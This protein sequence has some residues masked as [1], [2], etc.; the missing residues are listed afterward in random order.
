MTDTVDRADQ[1]L[2][3]GSVDLPTSDQIDPVHSTTEDP[4]RQIFVRS[5][6]T[7]FVQNPFVV[8]K[9]DGV[10]YWDVN[11]KKILDGLSGIYVANLGHNNRRVIDAVKRQMD[12]MNFS[13]PMHGTNPLSIRLANKLA[14]VAPGDLDAVKLA[15]GGSESTETAIAIA[16][17]YHK[18]R[19]NAT[20]FKI[21]SRYQ[22]WHGATLGALSASGLAS[23]RSYTEPLAAGF[24]HALRLPGVRDDAGRPLLHDEAYYTLNVIPRG[25]AAP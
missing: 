20:K 15:S 24:V 4:L 2:P 7:D 6:M 3:G 13:P 1:D 8:A 16:R 25:A 9:A 11:G 12:V 10:H 19:G 21:V 18:L 23:R 17:Q 14:E 22:S 5:Q